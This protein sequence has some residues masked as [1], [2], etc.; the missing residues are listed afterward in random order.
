MKRAAKIIGGIFA[1]LFVLVLVA[2]IGVYLFVTSDYVR[3]QIENRADTASGRKTKIDKVE[4]E[5][6]WTPTLRL[7]NVALSN[8]DWAKTPHMFEAKRI[9]LQIELWPLLRGNIVM[10]RLRLEQPVVDIEQNDK[11]DLNWDFEESPVA[12]GAVRQMKPEQRS[13]TP[14]IGRLEIVG[15]HVSYS[16]AKRKLQ[17]TG[18][19]LTAS[20]K[21]GD[22]DQVQLGLKGTLENKPLSVRLTGGSA[23]M[24]RDSKEPYPLDLAVDYGDTHLTLKGTLDDPFQF[25]GAKVQL[26]LSGQDLSDVFPL[27]G[28]PGPPTPPYR[29]AGNLSREP[30]IWHLDQMN[31]HAGDS[32]LGGG[33][34]ID[35][36]SKPSKL[37]ANLVSQHLAFADLAPLIGATPGK[38]G[39]VSTQQRQT[40]QQL[41]AKSEIFP[42][43]PMQVERLR[44]MNM[45]VSLYARK[46]V[47]PDYLPVS[48]INMHVRVQDGQ[49]VVDPLTLGVAGGTVAGQMTVDARSDNPVARV[50]LHYQDVDL[51]AFFRGSDYFDTTHGKLQGHVALAGNGRSLAQVMSSSSGDFV[52]GSTGGSISSL[53]VSL[54]GLQIADALVLYITGDD[55]IPIGCAMGRMVF[56]HG[57]ASFD[58]M[59]MDTQKSVVHIAGTVSL[60]AQAVDAKIT[61]DPKKFSLL[62][63]HGPVVVRGKIRSPDIS[64]GRVI[65][66]PTPD[67]GGAKDVDCR[68]LLQ[69]LES[70]KP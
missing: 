19:A 1:V 6:S 5:W 53:L 14:L 39:N 55:S 10:P 58:R 21:A 41:E 23:L 29:I 26:T 69:A 47:A 57:V 30:G 52:L 16:D 22:E 36:R 49:A 15:G 20:G 42:D 2:G 68:A 50:D 65:P 48:T 60:P 8:A 35:Q 25:Q 70:A 11:D 27:L 31:L 28:I 4:V 43:V 46:V 51:G 18:N 3:A 64:I 12:N 62:D 61:A 13:G 7:D 38:R 33:I 17:L 56:D 24:L 63:L 67:F 66:I 59:V 54:A 34:E 37:T 9:E 45:D 32:D 40:E 44:T